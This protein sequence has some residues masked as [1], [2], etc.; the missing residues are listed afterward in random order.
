MKL[1]LANLLMTERAGHTEP[2]SKSAAGPPSSLG[3]NIGGASSL[4]AP[5]LLFVLT[6]PGNFTLYLC[7]SAA[8]PY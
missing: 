3:I 7:L 4:R 5:R 1:G 8:P 6:S 2:G